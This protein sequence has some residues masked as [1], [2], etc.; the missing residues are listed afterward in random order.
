[1]QTHWLTRHWLTM[2]THWL[3][4]HADS[5]DTDS[6]CRHTDSPDTLTHQTLTHH[7]DTLTHQ[8]HWLIRHTDSPDTRFPLTRSVVTLHIP[9]HT[10]RELRHPDCCHSR[11]RQRETPDRDQHSVRAAADRRRTQTVMTRAQTLVTWAQTLMAWGRRRVCGGRVGP[12][13]RCWCG[14]WTPSSP[15]THLPLSCCR[16]WRHLAARHTGRM[17]RSK[18]TQ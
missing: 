2:Q 3:T 12:C 16:P 13:I 14:N 9:R 11:R 4:R 6:P 17:G 7:A 10:T 1:M 8:T 15:P 5:P 18:C